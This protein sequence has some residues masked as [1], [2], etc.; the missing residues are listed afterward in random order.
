MNEFHDLIKELS[1]FEEKKSTLSKNL[2]E[3]GEINN[4]H[5]QELC[6]EPRCYPPLFRRALA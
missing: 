4:K 6:W 2:E 3:K 5:K 1:K